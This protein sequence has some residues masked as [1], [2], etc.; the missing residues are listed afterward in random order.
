MGLLMC[1]RTLTRVVCIANTIPYT[2]NF[3]RY[4]IFAE[5]EANRIFA[6]IFSRITGPSWKGNTCYVLLQISN[7]CKLVI[8]HRLNFCCIRRWPWNPRNLHTAEI[9]VRTVWV[10]IAHYVFTLVRRVHY[11]SS[12]NSPVAVRIGNHTH[13]GKALILL[14]MKK[15]YYL[16]PISIY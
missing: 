16:Y 3:S 15:F 13:K 4:E 6:I 2:R 9:S 11:L 8:F 7:C 10:L 1:T 5:Q 12:S 14:V